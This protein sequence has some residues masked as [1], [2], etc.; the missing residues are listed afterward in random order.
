MKAVCYSLTKCPMLTV[1]IKQTEGEG[2]VGSIV[3]NIIK[4]PHR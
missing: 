3:I 1:L 2:E 4:I